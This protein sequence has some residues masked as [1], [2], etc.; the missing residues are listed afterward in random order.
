MSLWEK[1]PQWVYKHQLATIPEPGRV[2]EDDYTG[3]H[4]REDEIDKAHI[5]LSHERDSDLHRPIL[6]IDFPIH[7]EQSSTPGHFHLYMDKAMPWRDY[8][9]LIVALERAGVIEKGYGRVSEARGYTS[10][11][12]PWVRKQ[13]DS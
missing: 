5:I 4:V 2:E 1:L 11:R 9:R 13:G 10:V 12:L 7:I 3:E 8:R 6:D